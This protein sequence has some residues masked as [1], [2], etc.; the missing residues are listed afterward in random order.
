[1]LYITAEDILTI[2]KVL[3]GEH[4]FNDRGIVFIYEDEKSTKTLKL[5]TH[6][7]NK[8]NSERISKRKQKKAFVSGFYSNKK[9]EVESQQSAIVAQSELPYDELKSFTRPTFNNTQSENSSESQENNFNQKLRAEEVDFDD[10][11]LSEL[12]T[13][14]EANAKTQRDGQLICG[15]IVGKW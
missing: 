11:P 5:S 14:V 12:K 2:D 9:K 7:P 15:A 6:K 8:I 10:S 4:K 1:M 13:K 3:M